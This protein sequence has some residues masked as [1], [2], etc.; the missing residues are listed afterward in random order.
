MLIKLDYSI[1]SQL[2]LDNSDSVI[3]GLENIALSVRKRKHIV[4][5][6][7]KMLVELA[8]CDRLTQNARRVYNHLI[9]KIGLIGGIQK[10]LKGFIVILG[11][12]D[13]INRNDSSG[14]IIYE[15]PITYFDDP[16]K[17]LP[18]HLIAEDDSDCE[19]YYYIT[20]RYI[21]EHRLGCGLEVRNVHGGGDQTHIIYERQLIRYYRTCLA[22]LDS[23][24]KYENDKIGSTAKK[25]IDKYE[26]Y[27][28]NYITD[29]HVINVR[30]KENLVVPSLYQLCSK[31]HSIKTDL[32]ILHLLETNEILNSIYRFGDIKDGIKLR[33]ILEIE[34]NTKLLVE[35]LKQLI[36][37]RQYDKSDNKDILMFLADTIDNIIGE[38]VLTKFIEKIAINDNGLDI[39]KQTEEIIEKIVD[40]WNKQKKQK[41]LDNTIKEKDRDTVIKGVGHMLD[42]FKKEILL[43]EITKV[44]K[45]KEEAY[46]KYENE[47]LKEEIEK[48]KI[49]YEKSK[50]M[51][52]ILPLY[53]LQEW[54]NIAEKIVTWGCC[55]QEFIA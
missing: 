41:V 31:S 4:L 37:N 6:E 43:G 29:Y 9:K 11:N 33:E 5:A 54:K 18:L 46:K 39:T 25:V 52:E 24:K 10:N 35:Y 20:R 51:F 16:E 55:M 1:L 22:I 8:K 23:D 32:E 34:E 19:F 27:Q 21:Q 17:L 2:K 53:M 49:N 15:V 30:E 45:V 50:R 36:K 7:N 26:E 42:I 48:L 38:K 3:E 40:I 12:V 14:Q 13:K 44:I 47:Q 28:E